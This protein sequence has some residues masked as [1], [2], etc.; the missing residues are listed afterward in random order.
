M[1]VTL[2]TGTPGAGKTL[3]AVQLLVEKFA[4][5][6]RRIVTDIEGLQDLPDNVIV[7]P[8][9]SDMATRW[10]LEEDGT[11]FIFD[12]CQRHYPVRNSQSKPPI[13]ISEFETHR[14]RAFDFFLITQDPRLIDRHLHPLIGMHIH[15]YRAF[16]MKRSIIYEWNVINPNPAPA[17][18][19]STAIRKHWSFPKQHFKKYKSASQHTMKLRVP[20][21]LMIIL[22]CILI[23]GGWAL[24]N[25]G[26]RFLNG[27][28]FAF[29]VAEQEA[30][31]LEASRVC[32]L[33]VSGVAGDFYSLS[34]GANVYRVRKSS[35]VKQ[36]GL[37][38]VLDTENKQI[39]VC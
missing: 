22:G 8:Q 19:K 12:E 2:L 20:G 10:H 39:R 4:P 18:S 30:R 23:F 35:I 11:L 33:R 17:Q 29:D 9:G 25:L 34:G 15:L 28:F 24:G 6:G 3:Y 37:F 5:S 16:N 27:G 36:N 14:H 32:T 26:M 1:A 31:D 13:Y 38:Y 21:K 7:V